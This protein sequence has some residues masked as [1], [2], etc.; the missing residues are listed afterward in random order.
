M[1]RKGLQLTDRDIEI[2]KYL[3]CG[4]AFSDDLHA[5]FFVKS[6]KQIARRAFEKRMR[7]LQDANFLQSIPSQRGHREKPQN[8]A[9]IYA[10]TEA[11]QE[12]LVR[13]GMSVERIRLVDLNK[14]SFPREM[15]LT[16]LIRKICEFE[17]PHY[18]VTRLYDDGMMSEWIPREKIRWIPDL[19][20]TVQMKDELSFSFFL[21][22]D[23]G[24]TRA[25]DFSQKLV[26][27]TR[28][29]RFLGFSSKEAPFGI[30]VA[31]DS[32]DHI[33]FLQHV[34]KENSLIAKIKAPIAFNTIYSLENSPDPLNSWY[35]ADGTKIENIFSEIDQFR[36]GSN[37]IGW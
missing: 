3:A 28:V 33:R 36:D 37:V 4:P 22:I 5:R 17:G 13:D 15:I 21:E 19:L 9:R 1:S 16:G 8:N 35:R 25:V 18:Q 24:L 31:S 26:M 6:G 7:E 14:R 10:I 27:F 12:V 30:F 2:F 20:L 29:N 34:T 32:E 11:S 23:N